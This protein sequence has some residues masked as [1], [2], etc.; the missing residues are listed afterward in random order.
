M[1]S[2]SPGCGKGW[3]PGQLVSSAGSAQP[4]PQTATRWFSLMRNGFV[5]SEPA[6]C[7]EVVLYIAFTVSKV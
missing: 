2:S 1:A 7:E 6:G 3:A 5:G 4:T